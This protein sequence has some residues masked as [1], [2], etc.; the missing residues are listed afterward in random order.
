MMKFDIGI[1][2]I[3]HGHFRGHLETLQLMD[4]IDNIFLVDKDPDLLNQYQKG[5]KIKDVSTDIN[6][7]LNNDNIKYAQ[8]LAENHECP[9][10]ILQVLQSG[11]HVIADKPGALN[12]TAFEPVAKY[13]KDNN[14]I[15][16]MHYTN[17]LKPESQKI[18]SLIEAGAIGRLQ[19]AQLQII[20]STVNSRN[21]KGWYFQK[22]FAG[23]GILSW[24]GCHQLDMLRYLT[25]EEVDNVAA[26]C[27][28]LSGEDIT[29]E[30]VASVSMELSNGMIATLHAGFLIPIEKGEEVVST[31]IPIAIRGT[32]GGIWIERKGDKSTVFLESTKSPWNH[33]KQICYSYSPVDMVPS[34]YGGLYGLDFIRKF[35]TAGQNE[36][37]PPVSADDILNNFYIL[38]AIYKS[39]D[40]KKQIKVKH[41]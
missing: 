41:I 40:L 28:T 22:K 3:K 27:R 10:L 37:P 20:T 4:E 24:L 21:P 35:L 12:A 13:A 31:Q 7:V 32:E 34:G 38:D 39:N 18:K 1:I 14:L 9:S 30:D 15:L 25:S 5:D 11:K 36:N 26:M 16:S 23:G 33:S 19:S 6:S 2:G 29:V 8:V 17:R